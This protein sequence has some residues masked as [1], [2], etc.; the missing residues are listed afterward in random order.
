[1]KSTKHIISMLAVALALGGAGCG[2]KK[3]KTD[4]PGGKGAVNPSDPTQA[5]AQAKADFA[6]IAKRYES[7]KKGG[8]LSKGTCE[9]LSNAF[10][11]VYKQY[12]A[13]MAVAKFN[14][15]AVWEECGDNERAE[16]IYQDLVSEVPKYDLAYNN[17]GVI[18]WNRRQEGRALDFFKKAVD[19]NA[20]TRAPRNNLAAALRNK[21]AD[22]PQQSD[23][24]AAEKHLQTVLAVDSGNRLAYE[25]L[26]RLYY[27]RG[28]LKDKSYLLL[29]DLVVTQ[30]IRKLTEEKQES[31]DIYNIK[32]LLFM[33][34]DN[35]VEALRAFKKAVEVNKNHTDANMNIAMIAIRFRDYKSAEESIGIALK[36]GRQKKNVEAYLGLGVALRGQRKY[37]DAEGAFKKALD[38][39]GADPRALYNLGI[40]YHEHIGPETERK[41]DSGNFDK[42]P[43][44]K[45]KDYFDK[46][47]SQASG[48]K[49]LE[50]YATD[51]KNR[52]ANIND[53]FKNIEEMKKL[54]AEAKKLEEM[55]K[56][57]EEEEKNR[58]LKME[59]DLRK[60]QEGG[61]AAPPADAKPADAKPADPKAA[62][63]K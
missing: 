49:E 24:D 31:A 18:Y 20:N 3:G 17:L 58:L 33:E 53:Y 15:G 16:K 57:A 13:S 46:F 32:G 48:K 29:A 62:G 10:L 37:A 7:S 35:Q 11:G 12:G 8:T 56:K 30:A 26:A 19:A 52:V 60:Q 59:E 34:D 25:N 9:D 40:L 41:N 5:P 22:S 63:A 4:N 28:R 23:F 51:A 21:Y 45:A 39:K 47:V 1:M 2:D 6:E 55:A 27:D 50:K 61:G 42:K 36:D 14:A 43:Y 54:E 38:V 44:E